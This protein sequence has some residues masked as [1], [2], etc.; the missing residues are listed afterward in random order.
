MVGN[1]KD[2]TMD[3]TYRERLASCALAYFSNKERQDRQKEYVNLRIA[4][5]GAIRHLS[6]KEGARLIVSSNEELVQLAGGYYIKC[7]TQTR[8]LYSNVRGFTYSRIFEV[9]RDTTCAI[10]ADVAISKYKPVLDNWFK[11]VSKTKD[12]ESILV[13]YQKTSSEG[14]PE[15]T[16]RDAFS[17]LDFNEPSALNE[18]SSFVLGVCQSSK[19]LALWSNR[20]TSRCAGIL[21]KE[22]FEHI[23]DKEVFSLSIKIF[24][25]K[26]TVPQYNF[27]ARNKEVLRRLL[28][29]TPNM[30]PFFYAFY[31]PPYCAKEFFSNTVSLDAV[32][33]IKA[34]FTSQGLTPAGWRF[35]T[36]QGS[37]FNEVVYYSDNLAKGSI[38]LINQLSLLGC[39]KIP[40]GSWLLR[41]Y[42]RLLS[43]TINAE[44]SA[45]PL[46]FLAV[47]A[48]HRKAATAKSLEVD[49]L[50]CLDYVE[51]NEITS[52]KGVTW[53]SLQ[54]RQQRWH[55]DCAQLE[56]KRRLELKGSMY[57][58]GAIVPELTMGTLTAKSLNTSEELIEEGLEMAHCVGGYDYA[59]FQN[60]SRI[61]SVTSEGVRLATIELR[62]MGKRW[63]LSQCYGARNSKVTDGQV[64]RIAASLEKACN[65]S[66]ANLDTSLSVVAYQ[67]PSATFV[68]FDEEFLFG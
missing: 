2:P 57:R 45:V 10:S 47:D 61:Y 40:Y 30:A 15:L 39:K 25:I 58:W 9:A 51:R 54:R 21:G 31:A 67:R 23:I 18:F 38:K 65:K 24:G 55:Q 62:K 26:A 33:E 68:N 56:M 7:D 35:L 59:C 52:F 49:F 12:F 4:I 27:V 22:L 19:T 8:E 50:Q 60:K 44:K 14:S 29:E 46:L 17:C 64:L 16:E 32:S 28:K 41:N 43:L 11:E 1:F 5:R 34:Y 6:I 53:A 42:S 36:Q 37:R 63:K 48:F 13:D 20:S 3:N 66:A